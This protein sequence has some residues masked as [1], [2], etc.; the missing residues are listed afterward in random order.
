MKE[1][2]IIHIT[3][4]V[5]GVF[6]RQSA[7]EKAVQLGVT[8]KVR[9]MPD[10]SVELTATGEADQ[11]REIKDWCHQGPSRA[12]VTS[13]EVRSVPLELFEKFVIER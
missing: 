4:K 13:V 6:F 12:H 10:G 7:E 2:L 3:G 11:L 8:G 9:N 1:T 5:Q